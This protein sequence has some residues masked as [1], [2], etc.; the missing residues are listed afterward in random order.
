MLD[1]LIKHARI[2]DGSGAPAYAGDVGIQNGKLVT[3]QGAPEARQVI[4]AAGRCL[5]PGFIDAH[6]HGDILL[7]TRDNHLFKTNQG[8][9]TELTGQCGTT[10]FPFSADPEKRALLL[11]RIGPQPDG[12]IDH[13][14]LES[15]LNW[16]QPLP[17]TCHFGIYIGHSAVRV[18]AMGYA[19][20]TATAEEL[21]LMKDMVREAM[22][23]G[24]MGLSSGLIYAPSC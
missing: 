14:T 9:T 24:A 19:N 17:K 23:H 2:L 12:G 3:V 11:Q 8:I 4:D 21:E 5:T 1:Y 6:S 20:R 13:T 7:G 22:E 10:Q 15:Y 16:V 18:S